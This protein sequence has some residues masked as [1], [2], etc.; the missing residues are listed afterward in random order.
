MIMSCIEQVIVSSQKSINFCDPTTSICYQSYTNSKGIS[1][2]LALPQATTA[3][4]DLILQITA[5]IAYKW[6]GFSFGGRMQFN[7]LVVA[8]HNGGS[9][10]KSARWAT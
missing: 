10:V 6:V 3:P 4:F 1:F 7:P 9:V 8:W 5:P 2:G